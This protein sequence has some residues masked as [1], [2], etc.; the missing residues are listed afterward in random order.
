MTA[1][2]VQI[3]KPGVGVEARSAKVVYVCFGPKR[4]RKRGHRGLSW[5]ADLEEWQLDSPKLYLNLESVHAGCTEEK[6]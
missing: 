3:L 1:V 5:V 2:Q 4:V 6:V